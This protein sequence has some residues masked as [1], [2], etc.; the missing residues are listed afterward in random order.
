MMYI[1]GYCVYLRLQFQAVLA[2]DMGSQVGHAS[3]APGGTI[4]PM[5]FRIGFL[6]LRLVLVSKAVPTLFLKVGA[7]ILAWSLGSSRHAIYSIPLRAGLTLLGPL[8]MTFIT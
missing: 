2:P 8:D 3:T 1:T 7:S 5:P 6:C 4:Q